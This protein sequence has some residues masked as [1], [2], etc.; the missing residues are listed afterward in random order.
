MCVCSFLPQLTE[1]HLFLDLLFT[2]NWHG[3]LPSF[4]F[5]LSSFILTEYPKS[6]WELFTFTILYF[7]LCHLELRLQRTRQSDSVNLSN[8]TFHRLFTTNGRTFVSL[9]YSAQFVLQEASHFRQLLNKTTALI[10]HAPMPSW[11]PL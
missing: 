7:H 6:V 5:E 10:K 8:C 9:L 4:N 1:L 2:R 3:F 11:G